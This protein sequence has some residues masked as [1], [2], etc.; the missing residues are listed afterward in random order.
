MCV[1]TLTIHLHSIKS[2]P[3]YITHV[4]NYLRPSTAFPYCKRQ[5][6][7][8]AWER[9]Y[10]IHTKCD[11]TLMKSACSRQLLVFS[12]VC[13][14]AGPSNMKLDYYG[15]MLSAG[16]IDITCGSNNT[17]QLLASNPGFPFWILPHRFSPK[18]QEKCKAWV[19]GYTS[20]KPLILTSRLPSLTM[21]HCM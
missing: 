19:R 8:R 10:F 4:V 15:L 16:T 14:N 5:K 11:T 21:L 1:G 9:G 18:L 7:G 6:A 2:S 3:P 17:T 20:T 12:S 13:Q